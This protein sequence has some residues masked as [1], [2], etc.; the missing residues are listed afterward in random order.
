MNGEDLD[1]RER[2]GAGHFGDRKGVIAT[3]AHCVSGDAKDLEFVP[4]YHDGQ[5]PYGEWNV[6]GAYVSQRWLLHQDPQADLDPL[7]AGPR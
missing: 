1:P 6:T 3:A 7:S 2:R 4:M 5:A